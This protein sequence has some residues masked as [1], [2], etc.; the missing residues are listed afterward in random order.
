V[1]RSAGGCFPAAYP[2]LNVLNALAVD[3]KYSAV[4]MLLCHFVCYFAGAVAGC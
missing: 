4:K 1:Q 3:L 2:V